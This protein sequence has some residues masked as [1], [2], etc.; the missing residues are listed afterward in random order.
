[1]TLR[2]LTLGDCSIPQHSY[3]LIQHQYKNIYKTI[4]IG[5]PLMLP[6]YSMQFMKFQI[7]GAITL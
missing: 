6:P 7:S 4:F 5:F 3:T 2:K 1:M